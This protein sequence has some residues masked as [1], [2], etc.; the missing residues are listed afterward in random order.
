MIAEEAAILPINRNA[1]LVRLVAEAHGIQEQLMSGVPLFVLA[2]QARSSPARISKFARLAWL[3][4]DIVTA[5]VE[6]CQPKGIDRRSL[7]A[8]T[9]IP[10]DWPSQRRMLGFA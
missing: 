8:A 7:M 2:K 6:G 3:A 9:Q 1:K 4:P 10:L 5:I